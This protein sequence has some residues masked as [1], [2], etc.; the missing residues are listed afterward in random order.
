MI[1]IS[2]APLR[3]ILKEWV[4]HYNSGRS[5]SA[6]GPRRA[7]SARTDCGVPEVQ[8]PPSG[9]GGR[10]RARE[11]G[12]GRPASRVFPRDHVI[13]RQERNCEICTGGSLRRTS[14]LV[15]DQTEQARDV[16]V[17]TLGVPRAIGARGRA[18]DCCSHAPLPLAIPERGRLADV[19]TGRI[20]QSSGRQL[21]SFEKGHQLRPALF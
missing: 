5:H 11:V 8:I 13:L 4:T 1:P 15:R 3:A 19:R 9:G 18:F 21:L 16:S 20:L 17:G 12:A 10:V 2:E 7:G 6:L 14:V